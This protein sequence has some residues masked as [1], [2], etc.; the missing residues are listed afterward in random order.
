L[1][2]DAD[3]KFSAIWVFTAFETPEQFACYCGIAPFEHT[4]GK[5]VRG[6]TQVSTYAD[7]KMKTIESVSIWDNGQTVEAKILN[8]YAVNVTLG[9]SATFY[10]SLL[11]ETAEGNVGSQVAQGNLS[12]TGE[13]YQEWN[14]DE[15]AWEWVA[16]QLNL[17]ITGD[18]VAPEP[19]VTTT[20]EVVEGA[21]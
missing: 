2:L 3:C 18:Y 11:A 21:E 7:K 10:Y 15:F 9:T 6:K 19:E 1:V 12:M 14:Q 13:A 5:S 8:A 16:E 4:S 20:T 17:T